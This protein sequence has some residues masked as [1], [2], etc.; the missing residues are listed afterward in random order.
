VVGVIG[1]VI[2]IA[3]S[4]LLHPCDQGLDHLQGTG[5]DYRLLTSVISLLTL[6]REDELPH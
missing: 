6:S 2:L 1:L 3:I 4:A 5:S